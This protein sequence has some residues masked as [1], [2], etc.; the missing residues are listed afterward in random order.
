MLQSSATRELL[1]NCEWKY[2]RLANKSKELPLCRYRIPEASHSFTHCSVPYPSPSW[3]NLGVADRYPQKVSRIHAK[4]KKNIFTRINFLTRSVGYADQNPTETIVAFVLVH[5]H[6]K[7]TQKYFTLEANATKRAEVFT[8]QTRAAISQNFTRSA[9]I[10][11]TW[12]MSI[13]AMAV[14]VELAKPASWCTHFTFVNSKSPFWSCAK[15]YHKKQKLWKYYTRKM[16]IP[17]EVVI[18]S[19]RRTLKNHRCDAHTRMCCAK[20]DRNVMCSW[21]DKTPLHFKQHILKIT[22]LDFVHNTFFSN[23]ARSLI[24]V[25]NLHILYVGP[26]RWTYSPTWLFLGLYVTFGSLQVTNCDNRQAIG[27]KKKDKCP[28]KRLWELKNSRF[29]DVFATSEMTDDR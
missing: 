1:E 29:D 8:R 16:K 25:P 3:G 15:K 7:C 27:R 14:N 2:C 13:A 5:S 22:F 17:S 20:N 18:S 12:W 6:S 26:L 11:K 24:D 4:L 23:L 9:F 28:E 10:P 19:S 21:R